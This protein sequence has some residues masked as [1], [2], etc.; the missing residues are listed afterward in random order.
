[1][2]QNRY[3]QLDRELH[4]RENHRLARPV[5]V[6]ELD[7]NEATIVDTVP[8]FIEGFP[9]IAGIDE[10]ISEDTAGKPPH[11]LV[12]PLVAFTKAL[13][14]GGALRRQ[15]GATELVDPELVG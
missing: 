12:Q 3:A 2:V 10:T 5:I 4:D 8:D 9:G 7:P 14:P 11:G 15:N 6:V 13:H 1:M